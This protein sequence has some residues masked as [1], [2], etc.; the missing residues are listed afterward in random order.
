MSKQQIPISTVGS[1]ILPSTMVANNVAVLVWKDKDGNYVQVKV[2]PSG[3]IQTADWSGNLSI[4]KGEVQGATTMSAMG[5]RELWSVNVAWE[6]CCRWADVWWPARLPNPSLAWE[7]MT[8]VSDN[9]ND[10]P[11]SNGVHTVRIHYIDVAWDAQTEDI[12]MNGTTPVN[13]VAT[14]IIFVNDMHTVT[15]W[16]NWVARGSITIYKTGGSIANDLYNLIYRWGNKSL[17]PHRMV[18]TWS[19]LYLQSR[20]GEEAQ[21]KR[22]WFRIRSTDMYWVL[23]PWVFCYKDTA[24]IKQWETWPLPLHW[25]KI[26]AWSII[27]VTHRDD[28]SGT[29]WSCGRWGYLIED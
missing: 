29:E 19:S 27:K 7:Q 16:S 15:V 6:D 9:N 1:P 5:E 24:Y 11:W 28:Q 10:K 8:V 20:H 14:D 25:T 18:P 22:C 26:P 2:D 13:M 3:H 12:T 21:G 23:L 17:V 4:A